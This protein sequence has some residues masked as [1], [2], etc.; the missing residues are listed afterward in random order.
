MVSKNEQQPRKLLI[1]RVEEDEASGKQLIKEI[2]K[3]VRNLNES[4]RLIGNE[5]D[6]SC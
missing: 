6:A 2:R 4:A 1:N 3:D 5:T